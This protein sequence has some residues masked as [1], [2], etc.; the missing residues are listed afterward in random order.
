MDETGK[1]DIPFSRPV[2]LPDF[3]VKPYNEDY[4]ETLPVFPSQ[5][6]L[7]QINREAEERY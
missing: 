7:V 1:L 6:D 5:D 4:I 3:L 2:I